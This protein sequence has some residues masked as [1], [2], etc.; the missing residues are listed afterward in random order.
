M[1]TLQ[2][3]CRALYAASYPD[4]LKYQHNTSNDY[5]DS[6]LFG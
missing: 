2:G 5:R 3:S 6:T 1:Q 4:I